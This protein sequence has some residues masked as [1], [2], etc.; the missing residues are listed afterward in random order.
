MNNIMPEQSRCIAHEIRNHLSICELYTQVIKKNLEKE[1]FSNNSIDNALNCITK[2]LKIINNSLLD[3]KS[4]DNFSPAKCDIKALL[5]EGIE[6]SKVYIC[7]KDI[8][9]KNDIKTKAT[10][11]IDENKFL[12]CI[13]NIIKNAIE[14]IQNKG[15]I[16]I[17]LEICQ[18]L[19]SLGGGA[20]GEG[21]PSAVIKI[22]NNGEPVKNP[23]NIFKAGF[24]TKST[25]SGLGLHICAA[26]LQAQNAQLKLTRSTP[27]I[28]EFEIALPI[29]K[30]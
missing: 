20:G 15:E 11:Y 8:K 28:T 13:V 22:S 17:S 4:L 27:E 3:L 16:K 29:Y 21:F 1:N 19:P 23:E 12:A 7:E 30:S 18:K 2:S 6:L 10:V 24:T 5:E 9:I 26:N 14:A 25:G